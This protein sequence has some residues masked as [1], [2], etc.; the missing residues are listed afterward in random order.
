MSNPART[1]RLLSPSSQREYCRER[2]R[3]EF[4]EMPGLRLTIGQVARL[5]A[6]ERP[7]CERVMDE[8]VNGGE[9]TVD[10]GRF[11]VPPSVRR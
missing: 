2:I 10:A 11:A 5:I 6:V 3:E 9:L 7:E 4:A 1:H 8:L